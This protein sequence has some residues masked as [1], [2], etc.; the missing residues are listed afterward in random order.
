MFGLFEYLMIEEYSIWVTTLTGAIC[1]AF[2]GMTLPIYFNL[3]GELI[4]PIAYKLSV[5]IGKNIQNAGPSPS[6]FCGK[7]IQSAAL[8]QFVYVSVL[9]IFFSEITLG[10]GPQK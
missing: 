3:G 8:N 2:L 5:N 4:Y 1:F 7:K 6:V 10:D 9:R